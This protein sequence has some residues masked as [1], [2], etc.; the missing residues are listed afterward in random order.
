MMG[1][2]KT[3]KKGGLTRRSE[4]NDYDKH[5]QTLRRGSKF[6]IEDL[7]KA[8]SDDN[9]LH[10]LTQIVH[11]QNMTMSCHYSPSL[12]KRFSVFRLLEANLRVSEKDQQSSCQRGGDSLA[13][14]LNPTVST[15]L[16]V[17]RLNGIIHYYPVQ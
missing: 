12:V 7:P 4:R 5:V 16:Y 2:V 15:V 1:P 11:F 6:K 3:E 17:G 14:A 10:F 13:I 8:T 9:S